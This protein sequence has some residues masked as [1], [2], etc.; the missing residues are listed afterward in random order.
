MLLHLEEKG[1]SVAIDKPAEDL[2]GV[3]AGFTLL[4]EFFAGAA[5]VV[6]EAGLDGMAEGV[7]VHP[8]HH[9]HASTSLGAFLH[10]GWNESAVVIFEV[11]LHLL[12]IEEGEGLWARRFAIAIEGLILETPCVAIPSSTQPRIRYYEVAPESLSVP[13]SDL[14]A[15]LPA[16]YRNQESG[17]PE[18]RTIELPCRELFRGNTPRLPLGLLRDLFPD[19]VRLPEG[20]DPQQQLSLPAGWLALHFRLITRSE[21]LPPDPEMIPKPEILPEETK[22]ASLEKEEHALLGKSDEVSP[23]AV[24][25]IPPVPA[26]SFS[27]VQPQEE[28]LPAPATKE[29][30]PKTSHSEESQGDEAPTESGNVEP[31][32]PI[33]EAAT[34]PPVAEVPAPV[35]GEKRKGF[36]A[37]LPIFRRHQPSEKPPKPEGKVPAPTP[38]GAATVTRELPPVPPNFEIRKKREGIVPPP[39]IPSPEIIRSEEPNIG[40]KSDDLVMSEWFVEWQYPLIGADDVQ[41]S[42]SPDAWRPTWLQPIPEPA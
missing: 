27:P 7:L 30:D 3:A 29:G 34:L 32:Q 8:G 17:D 40:M 18:E 25:P 42:G 41:A 39:E 37:S 6:H 22:S 4:P 5:P 21:E 12:I 36:F 19:L 2:L 1:V 35:I 11:Q 14:L 33:R 13:A 28:E 10:D 23:E 38:I 31:S 16:E 24:A 26:P 15:R 20:T 9:Q